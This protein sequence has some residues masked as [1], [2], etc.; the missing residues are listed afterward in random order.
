VVFVTV[1]LSHSLKKAN[2]HTGG[3]GM[4]HIVG[5]RYYSA[6]NARRAKALVVGA[7]VNFRHY[8]E[9]DEH[10]DAY[11]AY[12]RR[13]FIGHMPTFASSTLVAA[14]R[15]TPIVGEVAHIISGRGKKLQVVVNLTKSLATAPEACALLSP[16][17]SGYG[18]Y[19]IVNVRSMKAYIGCTDNFETRRLQ[20]LRALE[21]GSHFSPNLQRDWAASPGVFAFV[22]LDQSPADPLRK[23]YDRK[24]IY[25][26][27]DPT[28]GYNQGGG[29]A[30]GFAP[31]VSV[32]QAPA[33]AEPRPV[34]PHRPTGGQGGWGQVLTPVNNS[35]SGNA[36]ASNSATT[37]PT[38]HQTQQ[39]AGCML[40]FVMVLAVVGLAIG[41]KAILA[42]S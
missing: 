16:A 15:P 22:V 11:R 35:G 19:A 3:H 1:C 38:S 21:K 26:T 13:F 28:V 2:S 25:H 14:G 36:T 33:A 10:P 9:S 40:L 27:E 41:V 31:R 32:R 20:H 30:P 6:P 39:P 18:V 34:S 8:Y 23:E 7:T 4:M 5:L 12:C 37:P 17:P 24:Y 29:F 42:A